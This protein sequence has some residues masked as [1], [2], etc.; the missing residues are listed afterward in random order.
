[1]ASKEKRNKG[2]KIGEHGG[3]K[4]KKKI[5]AAPFLEMKVRYWSTSAAASPASASRRRRRRRRRR[6]AR[7]D[8]GDGCV[9]LFLF[10]GPLPG[11]FFSSS[12]FS[13]SSSSSSS[14]LL[15]F[16]CL[17]FT[18]FIRRHLG[19]RPPSLHLPW[20]TGV[21]SVSFYLFFYFVE[22]VVHL[23]GRIPPP[24]HPGHQ[25]KTKKPKRTWKSKGTA[26]WVKF[27]LRCKYFISKKN[28]SKLFS[29]VVLPNYLWSGLPHLVPGLTKF[30]TMVQHK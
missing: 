14:F 21:V 13:S 6:S 18:V 22:T 26:W 25:A 8:D 2:D 24:L 15:F 29:L 27:W 7:G 10:I 4:K 11:L 19:Y 5:W 9:A 16:V 28:A 23:S 30:S 20:F 1:M 12:S 17:W 3:K